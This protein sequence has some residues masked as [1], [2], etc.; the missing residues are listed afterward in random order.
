MAEADWT[1]ANLREYVLR[2]MDE[3][4]TQYAQRFKS[5]EDAVRSALIS[6]ERAVSKAETAAE[7]RFDAVNEFRGSLA[8][9]QRMLMPRSEAEI[10]LKSL[11]ERIIIME[12]YGGQQ[13]SHAAGLGSGW[14]YAVG[15]LGIVL[16]IAALIVQFARG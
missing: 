5:Q 12:R 15:G 4:D 11:E 3:R 14:A 13:S 9:Q 10:R 8:D 1:V 7:K 16:A 2:I 6:A